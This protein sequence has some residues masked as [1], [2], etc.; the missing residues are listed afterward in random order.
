MIQVH[1]M[2]IDKKRIEGP[3]EVERQ[4]RGEDI[5]LLF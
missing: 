4:G 1:G 5:I 3:A 2:D